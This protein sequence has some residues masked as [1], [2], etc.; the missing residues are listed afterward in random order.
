[1]FAKSWETFHKMGMNRSVKKHK[2]KIRFW[3][4]KQ[5]M[6]LSN[7]NQQQNA[8]KTYFFLSYNVIGHSVLTR[9]PSLIPVWR[10]K[11][12]QW[13]K[14]I[15]WVSSGWFSE[16]K[17]TKEIFPNVAIKCTFRPWNT[18]R[19]SK[20]STKIF[21]WQK[22]KGIWIQ[23]KEKEWF[24]V[25]YNWWQSESGKKPRKTTIKHTFFQFEKKELKARLHL[26]CICWNSSKRGERKKERKK[27]QMVSVIFLFSCGIA[28]TS[29][30]WLFCIIIWWCLPPQ[31]HST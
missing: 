20:Q 5:F 19:A 30:W 11:E 28:L 17:T 7:D 18:S 31:Y 29:P 21:F 1:M 4:K 13:Q 26:S 24:R 8:L 10:C 14:M 2:A 23:G 27:D 16:Q 15:L 6:K 3:N 25:S 9:A 22:T 12:E